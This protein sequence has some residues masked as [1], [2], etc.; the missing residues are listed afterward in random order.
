LPS[1]DDN[2]TPRKVR[3]QK[4]KLACP[5]PSIEA[6]SVTAKQAA[7]KKYIVEL[8]VEEREP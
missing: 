4:R 6:G 1:G 3:A 8:S 5:G 7:I 2:S